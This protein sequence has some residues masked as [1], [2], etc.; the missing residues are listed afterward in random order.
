MKFEIRKCETAAMRWSQLMTIT[1]SQ[2]YFFSVVVDFAGLKVDDEAV[3]R[4]VAISDKHGERM[5]IHSRFDQSYSSRQKS[6]ET[7]EK[8]V[9]SRL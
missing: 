4:L 7:I 3:W 1:H 9:S 5:Q 8:Q 6:A 2:T